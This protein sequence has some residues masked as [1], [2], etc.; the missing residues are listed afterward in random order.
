MQN[1]PNEIITSNVS[2]PI[3]FEK[4]K[5]DIITIYLT[6]FTKSNPAPPPAIAAGILRT[7]CKL[8]KRKDLKLS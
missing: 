3:D 8:Q 4:E 1:I 2:S 6:K 7:R 5:L